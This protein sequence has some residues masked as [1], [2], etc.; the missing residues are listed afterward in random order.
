MR[1]I[2]NRRNGFYYKGDRAFPSVTTIL[3][4]IAKPQLTNW[5]IQ[6]VARIA[7]ADPSLDEKE[8]GANYRAMIK[9][10]AARGTAVHAVAEY[11][12][13]NLNFECAF[14]SEY[15]GYVSGLRSFVDTHNPQPILHELELFSDKYGYAG[16]CDL[17]CKLG[18]DNSTW[19]LDWKTNKQGRIYPEVNLQLEAYAEALREMGLADVDHTGVVC[20]DE[21]GGFTFKETKGTL[22]EFLS[23]KILWEW[24]RKKG[25]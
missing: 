25:D 4:V 24:S 3:K 14:P 5:T 2:P 10:A 7:L 18:A 9:V 21:S 19:L 16:K 12:S 17:V 23:A 15:S 13:K 8:V 11:W 6:Q 1:K 22:E 20:C